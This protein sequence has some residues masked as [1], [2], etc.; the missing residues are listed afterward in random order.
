MTI[1]AEIGGESESHDDYSR[2]VVKLDSRTRVIECSGGIQWSIQVRY[3]KRHNPWINKLW[4]RSKAGLLHYIKPAPPELSA[5]PDWFSEGKAGAAEP[6]IEDFL[7]ERTQHDQQL[8]SVALSI[9]SRPRQ[10]ASI[11]MPSSLAA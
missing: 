5:L 8:P 2:V 7:S 1:R 6:V 3:N 10:H 11:T 9:P 4:F